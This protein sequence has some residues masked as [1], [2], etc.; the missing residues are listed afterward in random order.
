MT[1]DR[2]EMEGGP[3]QTSRSRLRDGRRREL[4]FFIHR[5]FFA[6]KNIFMR[7]P[8]NNGDVYRESFYATK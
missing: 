3:L 8:N 6:H 7:M 2:H 1:F 5:Y 4:R